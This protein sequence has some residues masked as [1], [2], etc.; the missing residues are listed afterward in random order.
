MV[1]GKGKHAS[2]EIP[3]GQFYLDFTYKCPLCHESLTI[4]SHAQ[5]ACL[6]STAMVD[7]SP[8]CGAGIL[9]DLRE[10]RVKIE[11]FS[12]AKD[13]QRRVLEVTKS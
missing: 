3:A 7:D 11:A 9:L 2:T 1:F 5:L 13:L 10:G 6:A 4:P 12:D 8:G